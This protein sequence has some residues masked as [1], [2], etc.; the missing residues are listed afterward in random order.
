MKDCG[1]L[2]I[3][4][5]TRCFMISRGRLAPVAT[6]ATVDREREQQASE[7]VPYDLM[8]RNAKTL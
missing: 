2:P 6:V 8:S 3:V 5:A 7:V 4:S 1:F